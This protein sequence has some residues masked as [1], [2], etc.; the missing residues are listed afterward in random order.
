MGSDG[1]EAL[2][3][4]FRCDNTPVCSESTG[5]LAELLIQILAHRWPP[6]EL[7]TTATIRAAT[8]LF[9]AQR[10][11][12]GFHEGAGGAFSGEG[13]LPTAGGVP[14][15]GIKPPWR[16]WAVTRGRPVP[17]FRALRRGRGWRGVAA[18]ASFPF[19]KCLL[20]PSGVALPGRAAVRCWCTAGGFI[21]R[22]RRGFV[23]G[24]TSARER[25]IG[26]SAT[27]SSCQLGWAWRRCMGAPASVPAV[28]GA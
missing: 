25:R 19:A 15:L 12:D 21:P 16:C 20:P 22:R 11:R 4:Y 27:E 8:T 6:H 28:A 5:D 7:S 26:P 13:L 2:G 1:I 18:A 14:A 23:W 10:R 3:V 24:T 17:A 9:P